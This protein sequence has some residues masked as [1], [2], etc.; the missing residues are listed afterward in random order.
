MVRKKLI[1]CVIDS[2]HPQALE[3]CFAEGSVPA[4][5]F[6]RQHGY[7]FPACVS[8]FPTMT[9]TASGSIATGR[10]PEAHGV[11]G[12][13]WY[14]GKRSRYINYGMS[15]A[16]I[17]KHGT[18]AVLDDWKDMNR[19]HLHPCV[20]TVFEL[21]EAQNVSCGCINFFIRRG[22]V[23]HPLKYPW[24]MHLITGRRLAPDTL[25]GPRMLVVGKA[26][27]P[28]W[29][30]VGKLPRRKLVRR[31]GVN[32]Y[33]S[34]WAAAETIRQGRLP[35][36]LVVYFPG[37]DHYTHLH[38]PQA[39]GPGIREVD[40]HLAGILD[41]FGSWEGALKEAAFIVV[42]DHSQS[43]VNP[44]KE[45]TVN[46][47]RVLAGFRR[48]GLGND[49]PARKDIAV[50]NNERMAYVDLLPGR[51]HLLPHVVDQLGRARGIDQVAWQEGGRYRVLRG[52]R[53]CL[54]FWPEGSCTDDFGKAWDWDGDLEAVDAVL[55]GDRLLFHDYPDAFGR[56]RGALG[57]GAGSRVI[58][59]AEPGYEFGSEGAALHPGGG[60][61]GSLHREDS[62]VPLIITGMDVP[63]VNP[64]LVDLAPLVCRHF[65]VPW[66]P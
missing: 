47:D 51:E 52:N 28:V 23:E 57:N 36:F 5:Y 58:V 14:D 18:R 66:Q 2:L 1:L 4:L 29:L 48:L 33:V 7:Y 24:S 15:L 21:L 65:G 62:L 37:T 39:S 50:S 20:P 6:L 13:V 27:Y 10:M 12:F 59:T 64:R 22:P 42:G 46:L 41:A 30:P 17:W 63:L 9:P 45:A 11:P 19:R 8:V 31:F 44:G 54:S 26:C 16:A 34:G 55:S 60:S 53:W 35:E 38:G 43:A 61:H 32:D 25:S 3:G 49:N 40:A 56:I